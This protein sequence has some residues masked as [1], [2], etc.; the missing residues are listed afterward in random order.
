MS[1]R[2]DDC[3]YYWKAHPPSGDCPGP[4]GPCPACKFPRSMHVSGECPANDTELA[5]ASD[6]PVITYFDCV[7][8]PDDD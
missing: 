1:D 8:K 6:Y 3:G 5:L 7:L 2:C 4:K